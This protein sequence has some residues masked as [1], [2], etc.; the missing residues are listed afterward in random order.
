MIEWLKQNFIFIVGALALGVFLLFM[1]D[2][3]E[4]LELD[5]VATNAT[6]MEED[7]GDIESSSEEVLVD[8]KGEVN[9]PGVYELKNNARV[10]DVIKLADGF[11][12]KA[13]ESDINLAQKV[14]D[15][16]IIIVSSVEGDST[17]SPSSDNTSSQTDKIR[18]NYA[19]QEEVETLSGIGPSKAQAII[20]YRDENGLFKTIEDL[21]NIS[22]IGEKTLE[23]IKEDIQVP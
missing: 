22:G 2:D 10:N 8:I 5:P 7:S 4:P 19:T 17:S 12:K 1:K 6:V 18:I 11:T 21:L 15:E 13:N 20:D 14:H 16:M 9:S 23:N 3:N